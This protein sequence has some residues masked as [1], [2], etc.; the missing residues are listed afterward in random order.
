MSDNKTE[1]WWEKAFFALHYDLHANG[2]DTNLGAELTHEHLLKQIKKVNPDMVQCDCK[3]HHGYSSYPSKVGNPSPG[4][5]RD[6]LRI[7]RDVTRELGIP[8]SVHFFR[9][10]GFQ[11]S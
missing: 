2:N 3:G 4:I 9:Y 1:K 6:A 11:V 8:L 7:H 5:V 10:L